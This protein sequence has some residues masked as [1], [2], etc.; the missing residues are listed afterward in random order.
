MLPMGALLRLVALT[1]YRTTISVP[2]SHVVGAINFLLQLLVSPVKLLIT[3]T[4]YLLVIISFLFLDTSFSSAAFSL[5]AAAARL[6]KYPLSDSNPLASLVI[7]S[8]GRSLPANLTFPPALLV[9]AFALE[10]CYLTSA[11]WV[12]T[13]AFVW[14]FLYIVFHMAHVLPVLSISSHCLSHQGNRSVLSI[15]VIATG[16]SVLLVT[17]LLARLALCCASSSKLIYYGILSAST[18]YC[19]ISL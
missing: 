10:N 11:T 12:F 6:S 3:M 2:T 7:V 14:A 19:C 9:A 5:V 13:L 1:T 15:T 18:W 16:N 17:T 8:P 4:S